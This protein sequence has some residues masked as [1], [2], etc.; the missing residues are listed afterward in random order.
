MKI[1]YYDLHVFFQATAVTRCE[2]YRP[3]YSVAEKAEQYMHGDII[4]MNHLVFTWE[5][6]AKS[7]MPKWNNFFHLPS[8]VPTLKISFLFTPSTN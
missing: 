7:S 1:S 2:Q 5:V 6:Y 4:K 3:K 8:V